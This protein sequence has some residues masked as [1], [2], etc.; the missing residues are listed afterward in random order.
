MVP[1]MA[2]WQDDLARTLLDTEP[3]SVYCNVPRQWGRSALVDSLVT[4]YV[5]LGWNVVKTSSGW[6]ASK[7][8]R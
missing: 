6:V 5:A 1:A 8:Q 7:P 4:A 3:G 2:T